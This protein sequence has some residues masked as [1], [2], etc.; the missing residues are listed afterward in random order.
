MEQGQASKR[1]RQARVTTACPST[2]CTSVSKHRVHQRVQAPCAPTCPSTVCTHVSKHRV[3]Q[4]VQAPCAPVCPKSPGVA[5]G[6][7]SGRET[8]EEYTCVM[9]GSARPR[10]EEY[11]AHGVS[12]W[13]I[14]GFPLGVPHDLST[15]P[16]G[17]HQ[18]GFYQV[19]VSVRVRV[20]VG[21]RKMV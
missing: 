20:R 1:P 8:P 10:F 13:C 21:V 6:H 18:E 7:P 14:H 2:V 3:H 15:T 19:A 12:K 5:A 4:R 16:S 11:P 17:E 9:G